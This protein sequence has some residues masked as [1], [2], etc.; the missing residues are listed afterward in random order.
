VLFVQD[1][2]TIGFQSIELPNGSAGL[3]IITS[4]G[5][6]LGGDIELFSW[7]EGEGLI[8]VVPPKV[9]GGYEFQPLGGSSISTIKVSYRR[10]SIQTNV[11]PATILTWNNASS[12]F[13]VSQ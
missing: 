12:S 1:C 8:N 9:G 2:K 13:V 3:L 11:P 4:A 6:A 7:K 5:A 10:S